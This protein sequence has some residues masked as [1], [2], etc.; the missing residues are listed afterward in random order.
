M[1]AW[2][3]FIPACFAVNCAPGPNN[4]LAFANAAKVGPLYAL[5]GGLGRMPAFAILIG[6]TV[7]G[8]G[9][10]LSA[11]AEAFV[12]IKLLG[13]AYLIYVGV[14]IL[15]HARHLARVDPSS[16]S[17]KTLMRRDF[18]I[19]ITNPKAIAV[20]TAFFPQFID[21]TFPAWS[22]LAQLGGVFL[23]MEIVAVGLYVAA[24]AL[25][26]GLL[27]SERIFVWLN[28]FVGSALIVSG[29]SMAVS[30]R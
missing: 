13:A 25:L 16:V 1:I 9:A 11:S 6:V 12:V 23:V 5:L 10:I 24:G 4:M 28:R 3:L 30:S 22:Q 7:A 20:F 29:G 14:R 15:R 21:P 2:S 27:R 26:K 8:L 18:T 17:L 19:A